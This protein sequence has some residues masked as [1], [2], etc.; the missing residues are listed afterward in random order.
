MLKKGIDYLP[1]TLLCN[2]M[3]DSPLIFQSYAFDY[4]KST[5]EISK[6][7]T[8]LKTMHKFSIFQYLFY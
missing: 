7:Q 6:I 1:K 3:Q 4:K 8:S 2:L 5:C